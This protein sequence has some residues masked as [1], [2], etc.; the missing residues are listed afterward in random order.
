MRVRLVV[1]R[2]LASLKITSASIVRRLS[3]LLRLL[4]SLN[5]EHIVRGVALWDAAVVDYDFLRRLRNLDANHAIALAAHNQPFGHLAAR[6]F[7][8]D[9]NFR[10]RCAWI[11]HRDSHH[12]SLRQH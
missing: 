6:I 7:H 2:S 5:L 12:E 8:S 10:S 11:L 9:R 1:H 3:R 4:T